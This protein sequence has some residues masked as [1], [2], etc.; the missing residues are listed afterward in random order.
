MLLHVGNTNELNSTRNGLIPRDNSHKRGRQAV[1][2]TTMNPMEDVCG[3]GET[4]SDLTKPRIA[5][6]KNTGKRPQNTVFWCNL[7]LTQEKDLQFYQTRSHAVVLYNTLLAACIEKAVCMKTQDE[8]F[9]RV[10]LTP[11]APR[12]VLKSNSQYG[13]QD[14]QS[15]DAIS[16]WES[17]SDA[18]SY[19]EICNNTLEHRISGIPK[20][21]SHVTN[22]IIFFIVQHQPFQLYLLR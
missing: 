21:I 11:R 12:V 5:P 7:K 9:Q 8:L 6:H 10:R 17:S 19:G 14:P 18:K 20:V 15:E 16:S 1:S 2:F 22:G 3:M 4:P 13:Q